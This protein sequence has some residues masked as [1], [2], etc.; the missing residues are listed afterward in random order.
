M[1]KELSASAQKVQNVL[2]THGFN[3][4]VI[5]LPDNTRSAKE[6]A[7]AI[8]CRVEQIAKSLVFKGKH[9]NKPILVV[10]S[11]SNRV[12]ERKLSEHVSE[13][14]EKADADFIRDRTGF[15][16]GGVPPIGHLE[17]LE[18][19]IDEDLLQ[20]EKIWA[21]AGNP[22]AVFK[23]TPDDLKKMTDGQVIS[24]K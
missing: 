12:N 23:L 9:T 21:A 17:R 15:A 11:G 18:T 7:Q 16:I 20:H 10:A 1:S 2:E 4:Q 22:Y 6:A 13:P 24:V 3:C 14:V 19:F 5:E 8:R